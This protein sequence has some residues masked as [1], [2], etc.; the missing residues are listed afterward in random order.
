[1]IIIDVLCIVNQVF[2]VEE[3]D[4]DFKKKLKA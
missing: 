2:I 3:D 1:M 4:E